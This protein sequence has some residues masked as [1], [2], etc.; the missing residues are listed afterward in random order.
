MYL[1][2]ESSAVGF[3]SPFA[4]VTYTEHVVERDMLGHSNDKRHLR[5]DS[6]FDRG[7]SLMS[8]NVYAGSIGLDFFH[9]LPGFNVQPSF[10]AGIRSN[11][12]PCELS[13]TQA[14][15]GVRPSSLE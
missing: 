10:L 15:P 1:H 7:G 4:L 5:L 12:L 8:G 13:E 11:I 9:G 2:I 14:G 6:F 3:K